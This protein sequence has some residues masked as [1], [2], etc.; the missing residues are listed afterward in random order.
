MMHRVM[1]EDTFHFIVIISAGIQVTV[2]SGEIAARHF[3]SQPVP[4]LEVVA[5]RQWLQ[6]NL[7]DFAGF[8]PGERLVISIPVAHAL[9][10]LIQVIGGSVRVNVDDLHREVRIL[11]VRG[12]IQHGGDWSAYF[13]SLCEWL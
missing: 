1:S 4:R 11:R 6:R 10:R 12:Y 7:V 3:N 5:R 8:H 2:E 13:S 9:N